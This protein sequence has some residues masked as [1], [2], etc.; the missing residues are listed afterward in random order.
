MSGK[1]TL[2][3]ALILSLFINAC[4]EQPSSTDL[5]DYNFR[6]DDSLGLGTTYQM[7]TLP[8]RLFA[9][10]PDSA[11]KIIVIGEKGKI[12]NTVR[13]STGDSTQPQSL[14]YITIDSAAMEFYVYSP[15]QQ[16]V[17]IYDA[18]GYIKKRVPIKKVHDGKFFKVK[19]RF[20][21]IDTTVNKGSYSIVD[22]TG[23]YVDGL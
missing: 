18:D 7:L 1:H 21:F 10:N 23:K 5:V 8:G 2:F 13:K 12:I 15:Q 20:V 6:L 3:T 17:Y 22:L 4:Q 9:Y 19:G 16:G 11:N 14:S